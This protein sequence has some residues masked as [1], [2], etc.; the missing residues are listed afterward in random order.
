MP[1]VSFPSLRELTLQRSS[2]STE[3]EESGLNG[4]SEAAKDNTDLGHPERCYEENYTT[5]AAA[6][7]TS[8]FTDRGK[9]LC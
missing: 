1:G 4:N 3:R 6:L 2:R 7:L 9:T 5:K 8:L